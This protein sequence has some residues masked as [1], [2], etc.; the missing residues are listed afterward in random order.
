MK[1]STNLQ[2]VVVQPIIKQTLVGMPR[3]KPPRPAKV[4][5]SLLGSFYQESFFEDKTSLLGLG[6]ENIWDRERR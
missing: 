1:G 6:R 5:E 3:N 2:I 4:I